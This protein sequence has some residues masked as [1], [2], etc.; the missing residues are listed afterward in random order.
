MVFALAS[1][2]HSMGYFDWIIQPIRSIEI[3]GRQHVKYTV[4]AV[5]PCC[6]LFSHHMEYDVA[7][8]KNG[9]RTLLSEINGEKTTI[10]SDDDLAQKKQNKFIR[11]IDI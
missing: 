11:T 6:A 7:W 3:G 2:R 4:Y 10:E 5:V 8:R 9:N 1:S